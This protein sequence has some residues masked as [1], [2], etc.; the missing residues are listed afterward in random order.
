MNHFLPPIWLRT[1]V[2]PILKTIDGNS[3]E[4][5]TSLQL[6]NCSL[7]ADDLTSVVD[8]VAGIETL[9]SLN[10]SKN[11]FESVDTVLSLAKAIKKHPAL[12]HVG[13][14]HCSLGGGDQDALKKI[15]T[16]CKDCD[17][18]E[19][20]HS[21]FGSEGVTMIAAFIGKKNSLTSFSLT[22]APIDKE[23]KQLLTKSLVKN[24][25]ITK[26][27]LSSNGI[28]LPALLDGTKKIT[29]SMSRLTHLDLSF[30]SLP[31][32]GARAMAKFLLKADSQLISLNLSNNRM[33]TKAANVLLPAI[34]ANTSLQHLDLSHNWLNDVVAPA[35]IDLL[36]DNS[37][38]LSLD[39]RAN[40]SLRIQS[41]GHYNYHERKRMPTYDRGIAEIV[42]GALFDTTSLQAIASSNHTC[43]VKMSGMNRND[44]FDGTVQKINSLSVSEGKKIRYKIVLALNVVN[45]DFDPRGFDDVPLE[46]MPRLLE[47]IQLEIGKR[48][49]G[50]EIAPK[51]MAELDLPNRS[52]KFQWNALTRKRT[53][54]DP[55]LNRLYEVIRAWNTPLLFARGAGELSNQKWVGPTKSKKKGQPKRRKR[56]KFGD[57]DEDDE[58]WIPNGARKRGR[59]VWNSEEMKFDY[60]PP[61]VV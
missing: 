41:G 28:K 23:N 26:L 39:L 31:T 25:T 45:K 11:N 55:S 3:F 15:L 48:G 35:V 56:R 16:A 5:I 18:L 51:G 59:H 53:T 2:I 21:D 60:I 24:K 14:A 20:G 52:K 58:P 43:G 27:S 17:S 9:R 47:L 8:F 29:A 40:N 4:G 22:G 1:K 42:N 10:L 7:A 49:Y 6:S 50:I 54:S 46:L 33:A 44:C 13:L 38:L 12:V 30:N 61:T 36:K 32:Q 57:E 19:I 37:D 34:K